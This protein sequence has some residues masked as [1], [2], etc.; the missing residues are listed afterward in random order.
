MQRLA[1]AVSGRDLDVQVLDLNLQTLKG[2]AQDGYFDPMK[3]LAILDRYLDAYKPEIVGVSCL[4]VYTDLFATSHP[5]TELL[6]H[7]R[8]R[9]DHMLVIG[10]PTAT[11]EADRY[12]REGLCHFAVEGEGEERF[13]FLLNVYEDRFDLATAVSGVVFPWDGHVLRSGGRH[14]PVELEGDLIASYEGVDVEAYCQV[15]SLNPYSRMAGQD[16]IYGVFQLNRG[17]RGNCKFCDVRPFMGKGVRTHPVDAVLSEMQY[18]VEC[19]SVRHFE[20]L[21]DDFLADRK[22]GRGTLDRYGKT[23]P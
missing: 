5:L 14:G 18:L 22:A 8:S 16:T 17:C 6:R 23:A 10:G 15:G 3:W 7:L 12:V 1:T 19:R 13:N 9:D 21:D 4:T 2:V 11:N 20:L